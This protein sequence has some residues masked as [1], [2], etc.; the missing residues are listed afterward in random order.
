MHSYSPLVGYHPP[1]SLSPGRE[2]CL[3]VVRPGSKV[4]RG[5]WV[6]SSSASAAGVSASSI[7]LARCVTA[8][9]RLTVA[10]DPRLGIPLPAPG[11]SLVELLAE[12]DGGLAEALAGPAPGRGGRVGEPMGWYVDWPRLVTGRHGG[13]TRADSWTG[14]WP[15]ILIGRPEQILSGLGGRPERWSSGMHGG[16]PEHWSAR[17]STAVLTGYIADGHCCHK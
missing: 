14:W 11:W 6:D 12:L 3:V 16:G 10:G 1:L 5:R 2:S 13:S 17:D 15:A 9:V 8:R 4:A 7:R